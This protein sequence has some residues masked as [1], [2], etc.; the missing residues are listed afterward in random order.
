MN[1]EL[2]EIRYWYCFVRCHALTFP[3]CSFERALA[4]KGTQIWLYEQAGANCPN[5][6]LQS[7]KPVD[8][9]DISWRRN[10]LVLGIVR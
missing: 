4:V 7:Y 9:Y 8:F 3:G 6:Q 1:F 5:A 10:I 2:I